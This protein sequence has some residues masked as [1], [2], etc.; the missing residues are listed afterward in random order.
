MHTAN[1]DPEDKIVQ[2]GVDREV[3]VDETLKGEIV[4]DD[5]EVFKSHTGH[6]EF[7]A[8]GWYV[9]FPN[10]ALALICVTNFSFW[11]GFELLLSL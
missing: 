4:E 2:N 7:R 3:A 10:H 8:L 6:A 9:I 5:G 1:K 11:I